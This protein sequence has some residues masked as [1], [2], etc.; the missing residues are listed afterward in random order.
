MTRKKRDEFG[1]S[2]IRKIVFAVLIYYVCLHF[3]KFDL[4]NFGIETYNYIIT[5]FK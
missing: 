3:F 4:I 2:I 5:N 1:V